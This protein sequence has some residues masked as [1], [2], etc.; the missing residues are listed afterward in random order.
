[1]RMRFARV[2]VALASLTVTMVVAGC[3]GGHASSD[4]VS[5]SPRPGSGLANTAKPS[6]P[7]YV[8][9]LVERFAG[10]GNHELGSFAKK[11]TMVLVWTQTGRSMQIFTSRQFLLVSSEAPSGRVRLAPGDYAGVRVAS[12]GSWTVEV[13]IAANTDPGFVPTRPR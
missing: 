3:G 7:I 4:T 13:H 9:R 10:T 11:R 5:A 12:R 1:M 8:G 6:Q 2:S